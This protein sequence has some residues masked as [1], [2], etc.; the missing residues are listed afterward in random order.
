MQAEVLANPGARV[1]LLTIIKRTLKISVKQRT[2]VSLGG[3][4]IMV[5]APE[6]VVA[7]IMVAVTMVM[8]VA[9]RVE[10]AIIP[11]GVVAIIMAAVTMAIRVAAQGIAVVVIRVAATVV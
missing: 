5:I 9:V 10:V 3:Q 7:I 8:P 4:I 6:G 2:V 1:R 11:E